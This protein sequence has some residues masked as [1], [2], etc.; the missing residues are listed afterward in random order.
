ML[1]LEQR[2][3]CTMSADR[4]LLGAQYVHSIAYTRRIDFSLLK[5]VVLVV[6]L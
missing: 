2:V 1:V 3:T 5:L 4:A 6:P